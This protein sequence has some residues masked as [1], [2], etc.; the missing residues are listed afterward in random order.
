M[1][2][3]VGVEPNSHI[4]TRCPR[5]GE[6]IRNCPDFLQCLCEFGQ[7]AVLR[8]RLATSPKRFYD[9]QQFAVSFYKKTV[10]ATSICSRARCSY[11][12]HRLTMPPAFA[13][14]QQQTTKPLCTAGGRA[15]ADP[16]RDYA[17]PNGATGR[18]EY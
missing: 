7:H 3:I 11:R 9:F 6:A 16:T 4:P 14:F 12:R 8:I 10:V 18:A 17:D 5:R 2:V 1:G 15:S 13:P